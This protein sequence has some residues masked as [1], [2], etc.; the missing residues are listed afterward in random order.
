MNKNIKKPDLL[1]S[2]SLETHTYIISQKPKILISKRELE[3]AELIIQGYTSKQIG[4]KLFISSHTV[5]THRRHLLKK[6]EVKNS[7]ELAAECFK[8][9]MLKD[10]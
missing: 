5:D 10:P 6:M 1:L 3:I 9:G 7:I 8:S 4:L 2:N